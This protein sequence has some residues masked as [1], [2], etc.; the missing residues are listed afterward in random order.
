MALRALSFVHEERKERVPLQ[1]VQFRVLCRLGICG[2]RLPVEE[3]HLAEEFTGT[4]QRKGDLAA[5][6][7]RGE[8]PDP[9]ANDDVEGISLFTPAKEGR[10]LAE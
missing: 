4:Q 8:D 10:S 5:P 7:V 3:G 1:D 6:P 2:P 9:A